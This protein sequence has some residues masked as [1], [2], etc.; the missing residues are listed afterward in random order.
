MA[1][2]IYA[3]LVGIDAYQA[4]VRPLRG[5]KNDIH[6]VETLLAARAQTSGDRFYA[7]VLTDTAATRLAIIEGFRQHL[8]QAKAD[9]VALFYYSGHGSQQKSPPEFWHLEP[10][11][12]D[13]TLVCHDSR[14]PGSWDLADKELAQLI[15][16]VAES[17]PHVAV[18]LDCCHSGS[19]TRAADGM[20]I[21]R[22]PT[23]SVSDR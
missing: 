20:G 12:L 19:G 3:L 4:P 11:R 16:E 17:K 9:D 22:A 18:I 15:T 5:C 8:R 14:K 23:M 1:R 7:K 6:Q 13:E 21:R 2:N 10:D